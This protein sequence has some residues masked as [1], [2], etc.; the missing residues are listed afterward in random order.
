MADATIDQQQIG[1]H[2]PDQTGVEAPSSP[3]RPRHGKGLSLNFPILLP[4]QT[5]SQNTSPRTSSPTLASGRSSPRS[6]TVSFHPSPDIAASPTRTNT[7]FL[8]LVAAQERK[9]LELREELNKAEAELSSLKSQWTRH[10]ANKKKEEV[11]HMRRIPVPLD[12]VSRSPKPL[13]E[14]ELEE[15]R[16]RRKALVELNNNAAGQVSRGQGIGRRG[17][18]RKVFEGRHTRTL[19]LLSPTTPRKSQDVVN[20]VAEMAEDSS[21]R[22]SEDMGPS[23]LKQ[24]PS[25]SRMPTLD[26][27]ISPQALQMEGQ[28]FGKT[29]KELAA[30]HRKSLPPAAVDMMKQGRYVVEGVRDGLWTFWEDI[31]QATVGDEAVYGPN[32]SQQQRLHRQPSKK[33]RTGTMNGDRRGSTTSKQHDSRKEESFWK[34]FGLDTPGKPAGLGQPVERTKSRH[35]PQPSTRGHHAHAQKKSDTSSTDSQNP[36]D[37]LADS[38]ASS[39]P[40]KEE[41]D[42]DW[43]SWETPSPLTTRRD[44]QYKKVLESEPVDAAAD[45]HVVPAHS[46]STAAEDLPWPELKKT[47]TKLARTGSDLI[48]KWDHDGNVS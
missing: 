14:A 7:D 21:A 36:P 37:L 42:I 46:T 39:S 28:S 34:E 27:L 25:L 2:E 44:M 22:T 5:T 9:V 29:Y 31:R 6:K 43:D 48:R 16:K 11:R 26:G 45:E 13:D 15:E 32:P 47:P 20:V 30:Q 35:T 4:T 38:P 19:S 18:Q 24:K 17:S 23:E 10:E 12:D 41:E 1:P 8:T 3:R 33:T 40:S